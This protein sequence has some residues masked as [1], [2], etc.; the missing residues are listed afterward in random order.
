MT[1]L[2][3]PAATAAAVASAI[4]IT[5]CTSTGLRMPGAKVDFVADIKPVLEL[6]CLECHNSID[7]KDHAGL[8]LETRHAMLT[9]GRSAPVVVPGDADSSLLYQALKLGHAHQN[10]MPPS[11][12]KIWGQQLD[13]LRDWIDQGAEWPADIKLVRPQDWD[14]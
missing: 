2:T 6:R 11:P 8:D 4:A 9:T 10:A 3:A 7:D 14:E 5:A 13:L 12:D 1:K